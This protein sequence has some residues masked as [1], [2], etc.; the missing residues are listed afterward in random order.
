[1]KRTASRAKIHAKLL[2]AAVRR[3][4]ADAVKELGGG[5]R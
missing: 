1:V 3:V 5:L 4:V 2:E